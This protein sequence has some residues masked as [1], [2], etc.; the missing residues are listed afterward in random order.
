MSK[1]WPDWGKEEEVLKKGARVKLQATDEELFNHLVMSEEQLKK[2]EQDYQQR[3]N[4]WYEQVNNNVDN[5]D[6]DW[7]DGKSFNDTL[8]EEERLQRNMYLKDDSDF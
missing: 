6:V 2:A 7:G 3:L 8:T 1:Q 4:K 5:K